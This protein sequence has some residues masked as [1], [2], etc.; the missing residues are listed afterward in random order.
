MTR[1]PDARTI[2]R[3]LRSRSAACRIPALV[4]G[5]LLAL[6]IGSPSGARTNQESIPAT[7]P[8]V[9]GEQ[10]FYK[11]DW[12]PPWFLFF[13][14]KMEA[15]E[16]EL[17]LTSETDQKDR[18]AWRVSFRARSSGTLSK[19]AGVSVDDQFEALT[20]PATLCTLTVKKRIREGKRKRDID[21]TYLPTGRRLHIREID[22]A[23]VPPGVV[24]D[25]HKEDIPE[26]VKDVFS[27]LYALRMEELKAG[28][29]RRWV[30][31]DDDTVKEIETRVLRSEMVP[32]PNGPTPSLHIET[33]AL[34]GG[35]FK[36]GGRFSIWLSDDR[37]RLPLR[38]QIQVKLGKVDGRLVSVRQQ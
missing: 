35:L 5:L 11:V 25:R 12:D 27:A 16:L 28:H 1:G 37:R 14:P 24:K 36:E 22:V 17:A 31:G 21:V 9:P 4:S 26:C 7:L 20:D 38:F 29:T 19:L 34:L 2:H 15:G 6:A 32:G 8:F 13:L 10:L 30:V 23:R 18:P 3:T 33:V